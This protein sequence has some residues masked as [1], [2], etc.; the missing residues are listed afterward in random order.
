M[1]IGNGGTDASGFT[2]WYVA[3]LGKNKA[4]ADNYVE[5]GA[6]MLFDDAYK[7]FPSGHTSAA[8]L[9]F[10]V[11]LLPDIFEKLKKQKIWFYIVPAIF[12]VLVAVSRIVNRA[13]FLSDVLFGGT[14]GILSV[15]AAKGL[16]SLLKKAN[17]K[18]KFFADFARISGVYEEKSAE[19]ACAA[20]AAQNVGENGAEHAVKAAESA[21]TIQ[22]E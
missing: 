5:D 15:C 19:I 2:P 20:E 21:D 9:S 22:K 16:V 14:I 3:N 13:H 4:A 11:V 17:V 7:S 6:G 10:V 8:A 12:T 1:D 18:K